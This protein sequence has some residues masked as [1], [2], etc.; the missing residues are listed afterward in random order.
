[1]ALNA[2]DGGNRKCISVQ[3]PEPTDEKSEAYKVGYKTIAEIAKERI[4][5]AG[6]L[7]KKENA[8]KEGIEDL[9]IG[10]KVFK[11]DTSNIIAWDTATDKFEEQLDIFSEDNAD[12][13]KQGRNQKDILYEILLKYGLDLS[14]P[15]EE[16]ELDGNRIYNIG[17][18]TL[19]VCLDDKI[20]AKT[21]KN[22]GEWSKAFEDD[23]PSVVF[24]DSGFAN[25]SDKTNTVQTLKQFGIENVKSI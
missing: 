4:R 23:E 10:F 13:I 12:H 19:F 1:M 14:V 17:F 9:D 3:I 8:D 7:V 2:E 6:E 21:A 11:L 22:I 18:G 25:D 15:I 20:N 24:R 5:R 16:K